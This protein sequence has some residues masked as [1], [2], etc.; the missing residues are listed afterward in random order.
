ML[1]GWILDI[2]I[3]KACM[4]RDV[5]ASDRKTTHLVHDADCPA[6][7]RRALLTHLVNTYQVF[8]A[9]Q[10]AGVRLLVGGGY[11]CRNPEESRYGCLEMQMIAMKCG[12]EAR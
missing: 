12:A 1:P 3:L 4:Q 6:P 5:I 7:V 8:K 10:N 2:D 9:L 11:V